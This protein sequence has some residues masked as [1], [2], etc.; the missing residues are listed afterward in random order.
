MALVHLRTTETQT[1][2]DRRSSMMAL[3]SFTFMNTPPLNA[4]DERC[5]VDAV[6]TTEA[7][8]LR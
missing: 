7:A 1:D 5:C 3:F 6:A 8:S 2:L 4:G